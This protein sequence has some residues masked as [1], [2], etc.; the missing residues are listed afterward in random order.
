[1]LASATVI[2]L[3]AALAAPISARAETT[4][5]FAEVQKHSTRSDCWSIVN[6][7]VYNLTGFINRHEGGPSVII[8][9]CGIDGTSSYN[10]RHGRRGEKNEPARALAHYR[11]GVLDPASVPKPTT[12]YSL[13]QVAGHKT[14]SDCWSVVSGKVYNLTN[15]IDKHQGGPTVIAAMC[16]ID[17]TAMFTSKH[18]NDATAAGILPSYQIGVL[19]PASVPAAPAA[20]YSLANVKA[21]ATAKDCW[22]VVG[23]G[24]YNLTDWIARH[25]GGPDV[26]T[27][28]CGVDGTAMYASQHKGASTPAATLATYR[29][30][31]LSG[32]SAASPTATFSLKQ[33]ARHRTAGDCWT[34]VGTGVYDLTAWAAKHP[35]KSA[36]IIGSCGQRSTKAFRKAHGGATTLRKVLAPYTVG[37]T[38]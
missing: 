36:T 24:V 9:M 4:Y 33:V 10:S 16:G 22:S 11:I 25:P 20:T 29:I 31:T 37:R 19:D 12:A 5:T 14:P 2:G 7:G 8:A 32:A 15:W 13:A 35:K 1:M 17:G 28:M 34:I 26:I 3:V 23:D 27:A 18:A 21:H 38:R 30:G 6:G